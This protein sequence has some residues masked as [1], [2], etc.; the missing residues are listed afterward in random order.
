MVNKIGIVGFGHLG[1]VIARTLSDVELLIVTRT[2]AK[3]EMFASAHKNV[4]LGAVGDLA[5][6]DSILLCVRPMSVQEMLSALMMKDIVAPH[7]ISCAASVPLG[8]IQ[9]MYIGPVSRAMPNVTAEVQAGVT[10][11]CHGD[12]VEDANRAKSVEFLSAMG[13]VLEVSESTLDAML[14]VSSCGPG[15][16]AQIVDSYVRVA[17]EQAS[18]LDEKT[19]KNTVLTTLS[20]VVKQLSA[21]ESDFLH[22]IESVATPGGIT[23]AGVE[24]LKGDLPNV[25]REAMERMAERN[26]VVSKKICETP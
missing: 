8:F 3:A 7:L 14:R 20:G 15:L 2:R 21:N 18:E 17:C 19:V 13:E 12:A 10:F 1:S 22:Y 16:L 24:V 23:E 25:F 4:A 5:S 9:S 6:C 26:N 11:L